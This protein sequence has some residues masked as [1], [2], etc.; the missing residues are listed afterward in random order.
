M[1]EAPKVLYYGGTFDPVHLGHIEPVIALAESVGA[2][3]LNYLPC[4]IPPHKAPARVTG[5]HRVNMLALALKQAQKHTQINLKI[6]KYELDKGGASYTVQTLRHL[7]RDCDSDTLGFVIGM[8]SLLSLTSWVEWQEILTLCQLY[9]MKRPGYELNT[10][11]L[12]PQVQAW[13]KKRIHVIDTPVRD[14]SSTHVRQQLML[15]Q[16]PS[17]HEMAAEVLA[18]IERHQLY[19]SPRL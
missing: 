3:E 17:M 2:T 16:T 14:V 1:A 5:E 9:V 12:A 8:D 18:Y 10:Q 7:N 6:D 13:L 11:A 19:R 4:Y 15:N